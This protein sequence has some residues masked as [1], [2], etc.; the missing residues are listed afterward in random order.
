[1]VPGR[2]TTLRPTPLVYELAYG[3]TEESDGEVLM[4]AR[5][6]VGTGVARNPRDLVGRA[7]PVL[8]HPKAPLHTGRPAPAAFA[9]LHEGWEP[10]ASF[11]GT[12]D[13]EWARSRAPVRPVDFDPRFFCSAPPELWSAQPLRGDEL[14]EVLGA[15]PDGPWQFALPGYEPRFALVNGSSSRALATHLDTVLVDADHG[16]IEL[17][18]RTAVPA[19][20]KLERLGRIQVVDAANTS[21]EA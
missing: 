4:D 10:R 6:P 1:V 2:A 12:Y 19:P 15:W 8:E 21:P 5:N 14:V 7:A 17:T 9:P 20:R 16:R 18:W 11:G 3:G 13:E